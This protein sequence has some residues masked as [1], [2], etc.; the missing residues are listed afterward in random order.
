MIK[1]LTVTTLDLT[2][3]GA[4]H[5]L[6]LFDTFIILYILYYNTQYYLDQVF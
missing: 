6:R 3:L 2:L 5:H 1:L 4:I